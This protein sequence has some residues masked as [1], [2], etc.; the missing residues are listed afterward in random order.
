MKT[1]NINAS[2]NSKRIP[3]GRCEDNEATRVVFDC[4]GFSSAYGSGQATLLHRRSKEK[5]SYIVQNVTQEDDTVTWT[6]S[7]DDTAFSGE[8]TLQLMWTVDDVVIHS[9]FYTTI[10][11]PS[12][13]DSSTEPTEV[14]SALQLL[15]D[16][17]YTK[18]ETDD[19]IAHMQAGSDWNANEGEDGYIENRP[20][21]T[22][23]V[24]GEEVVHQLDPKYI[25]GKFITSGTGEGSEIFNYT[26]GNVASGNYS[27]AEGYNTTASGFCSHNEG[28]GGKYTIKYTGTNERKSPGAVGSDSHVEGNYGRAEGNGSHV[29]GSTCFTGSASYG[30][31]EGEWTSSIGRSSHSEGLQTVANGDYSH[32]EG[33]NCVTSSGASCSHAEGQGS[34]ARGQYSH[35]EGCY[36]VATS[37]ASHVVG[38]YNV[39]DNDK[40]YVEIVGNGTYA[41]RSNARTLDWSGNESLAGSL[42]LGMN[43]ND[44]IT[45]T[46][47]QLAKLFYPFRENHWESPRFF[48][49]SGYV[50]YNSPTVFTE[51][52]V[53]S[54]S[55]T[56]F[57][58]VYYLPEELDLDTISSLE[59]VS[60]SHIYDSS[61]S[62][63]ELY[64]THKTETSFSSLPILWTS[65]CKA[66]PMT[67]FYIVKASEFVTTDSQSY[68]FPEI[69]KTIAV[70]RDATKPDQYSQIKTRIEALSL[71][72]TPST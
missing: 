50:T 39:V 28:S 38:K 24:E 4:S 56:S 33:Q 32:S 16:S 7:S 49:P 52:N 42:T 27:H 65:G 67:H 20:F 64:L 55:S 26:S 57:Y 31:A 12:L 69:V 48:L 23:T 68:N 70:L 13:T 30:H 66:M 47:A 9:H 51:Q 63:Y 6:V 19:L 15:I 14:K 71:D 54:S 3:I 40:K 41:T 61:S 25:S 58:A 11:D 46:P 59:V 21:Y 18:E 5:I 17:C 53:I 1:V 62:Q 36:T 29:E 35:S 43:T 2:T 10:T 22:E 72:W 34:E 45:I 37:D 60:Y 44:E 8:G